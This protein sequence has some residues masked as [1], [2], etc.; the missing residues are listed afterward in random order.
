M[1]SYQ[2]KKRKRNLVKKE[3]FKRSKT[4]SNFIWNKRL[5]KAIA[6]AQW[7]FV[8][9]KLFPVMVE[10]EFMYG[11]TISIDECIDTAIKQGNIS[12]SEG[13]LLREKLKGNS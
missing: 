7:N 8:S 13:I 3:K 5:N 10:T 11:R 4:Y 6:E 2:N 12:L 9:K 1:N